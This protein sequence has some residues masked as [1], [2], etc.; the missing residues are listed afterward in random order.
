M[1]EKKQ[2][3]FVCFSD[4]EP[5]WSIFH[6]KRGIWDDPEG[7]G[8]EHGSSVGWIRWYLLFGVKRLI[9][10]LLFLQFEFL[11]QLELI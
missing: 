1:W 10:R 2:A 4:Q 5:F 3:G 6:Q 7:L 11:V 8:A 9:A